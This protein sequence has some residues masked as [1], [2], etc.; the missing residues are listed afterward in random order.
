[1]FVLNSPN[2]LVK[3]FLLF[4]KIYIKLTKQSTNF[5]IFFYNKLKY[6]IGQKYTN[7]TYKTTP[8]KYNY[9]IHTK[10]S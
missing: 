2:Y 3:F 5:F 7:K 8:K 4:C 10:H 9:N 6:N 1:M